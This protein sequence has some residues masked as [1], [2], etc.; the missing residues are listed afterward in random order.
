MN[1]QKITKAILPVAGFGTRFL[2]ATRAQPKE[3]LPIFDIPA[4]QLIVE[5]AVD[6]GITD[7]IMVT[8]RDK[9]AIEDHFDKNFELEQVLSDK[10]KLEELA[11]VRRI[12]K[13]ANIAY[14][15]QSKP[16]GDGHAILCAK[17]FVGNEPV[18]VLFGDDIVKNKGGKNAVQQLIDSYNVVQKPVVML[19]EV[20]RKDVSKYGIADILSSDNAIKKITG[21]VEKPS[22]D[23]AP[24]NFGVIGKYIITPEIIKA[25]ETTKP[26][27]D[28]EIRLANAFMDYLA[29]GKD[30]FGKILEGVRYDTG[31]KLGFLK[32]TVNEALSRED[33][34]DDFIHFLKNEIKSFE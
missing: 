31:D 30:L 7:I 27:K 15:R 8:G 11:M 34:K 21:F 5:E 18:V 33:I 22:V 19:Q 9:R 2:P 20:P 16:L 26:G 13:M 4:I 29:D 25:L 1:K 32:A 23:E 10:G 3:M 17:N 6:A 24:S 28:G 14:V 12:S